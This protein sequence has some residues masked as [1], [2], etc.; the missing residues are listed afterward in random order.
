MRS[1]W[2]YIF[3]VLVLIASVVWLA[4]IYY[5][6]RKLHLIACDVGQGD[7]ILAIYGNTQILIDGGEN[8]KVLDCLASHMPFWDRKIEVVL[9]THP[10]IDHFGGLR[11]VF[12]RFQ[13]EYFLATGLDS[14]TQAYQA[15]KNA[16]GGSDAR[17]VN[18]TSD[19]VIRLGSL[20]LDVVWP[21]SDFIAF[22]ADS[23]PQNVLGAYSSKEDPNDYSI[24]ANLR[25]GEF[26]ALLT[27]DIGPEVID[28]VLK[29]GEIRDV[30]YIKVPH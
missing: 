16:V 24:V 30:E 27:G 17:V 25:L 23:L 22:A 3:T 4:V 2:K 9:L 1:F 29:T 7:A 21:T 10:Q 13:V 12:R 28:K 11:D 15:L 8:N 6:D 18:P 19:M 20:Y 26:E 5:P 14:S